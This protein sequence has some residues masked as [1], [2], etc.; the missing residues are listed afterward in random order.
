[1]LVVC[2]DDHHVRPFF[3]REELGHSS[4]AIHFINLFIYIGAG[5]TVKDRVQKSPHPW[6]CSTKH[7]PILGGNPKLSLLS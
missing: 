7:G 1:M 6:T 4:K 2:S 3:S 5:K